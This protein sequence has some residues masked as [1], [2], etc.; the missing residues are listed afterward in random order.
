MST[1][2][3]VPRALTIRPA[4]AS[5]P[6]TPSTSSIARRV[7][8]PREGASET[9]AETGAK[10]GELLIW[11][12]I[13]QAAPTEIEVWA[14]VHRPA[15]R[16]LVRRS[17]CPR[18]SGPR[19]RRCGGRPADTRGIVARGLCR[20]LLEVPAE[21]EAHRRQDLVRELVLVA[22][23]EAREQRRGQP[24]RRHAL[25]DRRVR[26]PAA[27][28]RVRHPARE[29]LEL[30]ALDERG[31]GEVEQPRA[32]DAAAPPDLG[33]RRDVE[34]VL[35]ELGLAQRRRLGVDDVIAPADAGLLDDV[36][37]LGEGGHHAVLDA[38]VDHLHEVPGAARAA[39][40]VAV[41][42]LRGLAVAP[43]RAVGRLDARRER[44][45]EGVEARD[46]RVVA[47]DHQAVAALEAEHAA[48]RA[49]V[50]VVQAL[51]AQRPR[52]D[53]VV[54]VVGVAAVDDG[55]VLV[56]QR[57]ELVE[58]RVDDRGRDHDADAPRLLELRDEVLHRLG[59]G[60][61]LALERGDRVGADV[62]DDA[63]VA[64]AHQPADHVGPHAPQSDHAHLHLRPPG[65]LVVR[66][67]VA[68]SYPAPVRTIGSPA[69]TTSVCS[70]CAD[71]APS[72][73][74]IVQPS[75]P[76]RTSPEP[77]PRIGSIVITVPAC[78]GASNPGT[79]TFGT[80]GSSWIERPIPWPVS[81][82]STA[83]PR[84]SASSC[85]APPIAFAG[86][87][88]RAAAMPRRGA[89]WAGAASRATR[90]GTRPTATLIAA[91][92]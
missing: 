58:R 65:R 66:R 74:R 63:V 13:A 1:G 78:S 43:G 9:T 4:P 32:D 38:V 39:V 26:R 82:P 12:A 15:R 86:A 11:R 3:L 84:R 46:G 64:A 73:V 72:A 31:R 90:G 87:P 69:D 41:F 18:S 44:L 76:A 75:L 34:V 60:R 83:Q 5:P 89:A 71:G 92:A 25:V 14:I 52:P 85:T 54:A 57:D 17:T 48:A 68:P 16:R 29:L 7:R 2:V 91:S 33:D 8:C 61:A 67:T 28:A 42:G 80:V 37:A 35:V 21:G 27:L 40:Q 10:N 59:A 51:L 50:D 24:R 88:A 47:A 45:E 81:S 49:H 70:A 6:A 30:R 77:R 36:Q 20:R 79:N 55:V 22:R 62:V 56:E 19:R 53:D 23:G